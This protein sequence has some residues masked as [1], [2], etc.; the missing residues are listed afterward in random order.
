[1]ID[2]QKLADLARMSVSK[3]ELEGF[4]KDLDS[5]VAFVDQIKSRDVSAVATYHEKLNVFREDIVAPLASAYDLVEATPSHQD[6]FVK[7]PKIIE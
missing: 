6:G 3:D 4:T 7:V 5:I 1:M 2:V